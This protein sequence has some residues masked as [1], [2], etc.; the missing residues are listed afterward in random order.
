M[1]NL[2]E[3]QKKIL[4]AVIKEFMKQAEAVGSVS[5]VQKHDFHVSSATVRNEMSSLADMGYLE[6]YHSSSG[7]IPTDLA[8][9]FF[10]SE[11]MDE[12][13]LR[14]MQEVNAKLS[15]FQKRFD[16]EE[17][18]GSIMDFLSD[19]TGYASVSEIDDNVRFTGVSRLTKYKELRDIDIIDSVL[20]M[21]E[22]ENMMNKLFD[23][24]STDDICVLIGEECGGEGLSECSLVFSPFRYV[25]EKNGYIGIL[26]PRRMRYSKVVPTVRFVKNFIQDSVRGW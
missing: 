6:K 21:L 19:A 14:N 20:V 16:E 17:F 7:R 5:I 3:R 22:D 12:R 11:L 18:I 4:L 15:L 10:V 9:R 8:F 2:T 26:G 23:K 13:P 1:S 25:G 24:A